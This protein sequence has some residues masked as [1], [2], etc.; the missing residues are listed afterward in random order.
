M[1]EYEPNEK[2]C[3]DCYALIDVTEAEQYEI[4]QCTECGEEWEWDGLILVST[5]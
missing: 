5:K 4:V 2:E 1:V 3:P